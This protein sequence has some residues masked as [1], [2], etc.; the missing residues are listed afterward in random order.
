MRKLGENSHVNMYPASPMPNNSGRLE[1][2]SV[3]LHKTI[4]L[5]CFIVIIDQIIYLPVVI[6][7]Y[8]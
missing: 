7:P 3:N 2:N 8:K 4:K 6:L 1:P 5:H